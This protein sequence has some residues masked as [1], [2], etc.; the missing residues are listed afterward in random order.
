MSYCGLYDFQHRVYGLPNLRVLDLSG[1]DL[2]ILNVE[3]FD[4]VPNLTYLRLHNTLL[5][6]HFLIQSGSRLLSPLTKLEF[7]DISNNGL[8]SLPNDIF[9]ELKNL[10]MIVLTY[11]KL[12]SIPEVTS[13][14]SLKHIHMSYNGLTTIDQTTRNMLD[15]TSN[16]N[17]NF[18]ISLYGNVLYCGCPS[19]KF[20]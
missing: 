11:N 15:G 9:S 20:L 19:V 1:N 12:I 17:S 3:F 2:S 7:L 16:K 5:N 14:M 4:T 18:H 6:N 10:Q 8:A 13:L